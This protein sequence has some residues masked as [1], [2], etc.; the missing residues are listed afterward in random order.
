MTLLAP[1]SLSCLPLLAWWVGIRMLTV[2]AGSCFRSD[3]KVG[4]CGPLGAA[5][6]PKHETFV[7][8]V[9]GCLHWLHSPCRSLNRLPLLFKLHPLHT[10][11]KFPSIESWVCGVNLEKAHRVQDESAYAFPVYL[12][13]GRLSDPDLAKAP[14]SPLVFPPCHLRPSLLG[15]MLACSEC[16]E[17][18][19]GYQPPQTTLRTLLP[20]CYFPPTGLRPDNIQLTNN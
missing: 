19:H 4:R 1:R 15:I 14:P 18:D 20:S 6:E 12:A 3:Q 17:S 5:V 8:P 2:L 16:S 7:E 10:F 13:L 11:H 9:R